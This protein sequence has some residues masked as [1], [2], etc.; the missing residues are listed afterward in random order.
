VLNLNRSFPQL[1]HQCMR[2]CLITNL[3]VCR[4]EC[5]VFRI[6][7]RIS[8]PPSSLQPA[9]PKGQSVKLKVKKRIDIN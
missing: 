2:R 1:R 8:G 7:D 5:Y 4:R 6:V 3:E 9:A